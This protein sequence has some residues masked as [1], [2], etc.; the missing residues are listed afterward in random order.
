MKAFRKALLITIV[1]ITLLLSLASCRLE[2]DIFGDMFEK[3]ITIEEIRDN[4]GDYYYTPQLTRPTDDWYKYSI[5]NYFD[6]E[7]S[8]NVV[9]IV[10][11]TPDSSE[12]DSFAAIEFEDKEDAKTLEAAL[13]AYSYYY[14]RAGKIVLIGYDIDW[15]LGER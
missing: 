5:E 4:L 15:A 6:I 7:L 14:K 11:V 12:S 1:V 8:G 13:E 10:T 3:Q 9:S 2:R